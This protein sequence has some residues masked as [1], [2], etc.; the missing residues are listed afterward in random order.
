M[1]RG[2][3]EAERIRKRILELRKQERIYRE[4]NR[5]E[6]WKPYPYQQIA[7]QKFHEGANIVIMPVCNKVGKTALG[8]NLILSWLMGYEPWNVVPDT[9]PNAIKVGEK[10]YSPSSL[11][12]R[13]P[14]NLRVTGEDW[15]KHIEL[16]LI[17]EIRKWAKVGTYK[18]Q[19]NNVGVE[20]FWSFKNGST[21]DIMTYKQ[22]PATFEGWIGHGWWADEPP[23]KE[24]W[25][26]MSRGLFSYGGK[27]FM[28]M[29]PLS[30]VWI[31]D[32][33]IL[34]GREDISIVKNITVWDNPD[35]YNHDKCILMKCGLTE[36][37]AVEW[38][39]LQK[40]EA[41]N[42]KVL[43]ECENYLKSKIGLKKVTVVDDWGKER[44]RGAYEYAMQSLRIHR[45]IKDLPDDEERLPRIFGEFKSLV[46]KVLKE[47]DES[48]HVIDPFRVSIDLPVTAMIDLHLSTPQAIGF[49]MIDRQDRVFVID[50][51]WE[52]LSP[53]EIAEEIIRKKKQ[54]L[55]RLERA[56]IDPL[57]K[58]DEKF[59]KNRVGVQDSFTI[60]ADKLRPYGIR[61]EIASKDKESGIRNIKAL[62]KGP[63]KIPCLFLF[64]TCRRHLYEIQRWVYDS[65]GK[66]AKENDHFMENLYRFTLTGTKF[67][68]PELWNKKLNYVSAGLAT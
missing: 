13:P 57:A 31:L 12:I 48:I 27:V 62:L 11:G 23:P 40:E 3:E 7:L 14:V 45:F 44:E 49:Y 17:P 6:F 63:N 53:E 56:F 4:S 34:S 2:D 28:S 65:T 54:N 18:T 67:T 9:Y 15:E 41:K 32:E 36:E 60:I 58:G 38:L 25:S 8:A 42:A 20:A 26:S 39:N 30:E 24:I 33:L 29:T 68:P 61:L 22:E 5:I 21:F 35:L 46:G 50:E 16:T 55:W 64:R 19:K 47:F 43:T 37:E 59:M 1:I 10:F 66:P 51:I 52:N